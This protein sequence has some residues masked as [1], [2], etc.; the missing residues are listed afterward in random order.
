MEV[1]FDAIQE[2]KER[3]FFNKIL[4]S[5]SLPSETVDKLRD[6]AGQLLD[7]SPEFQR[8]LN[9]LKERKEE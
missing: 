2:E 9:D 8:L 1:N 3:G 5:Y 7:E 6:V 4:T